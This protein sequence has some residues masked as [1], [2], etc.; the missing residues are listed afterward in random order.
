MAHVVLRLSLRSPVA[1]CQ[2]PRAEEETRPSILAETA[3]RTNSVAAPS[4]EYYNYCRVTQYCT[5]D[6]LN[7]RGI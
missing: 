6:M 4:N 1:D 3:E 5:L 7:S 2:K